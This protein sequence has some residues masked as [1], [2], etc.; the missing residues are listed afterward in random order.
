MMSSKFGVLQVAGVFM[1]AMISLWLAPPVTAGASSDG[2]SIS[3]FTAASISVGARTETEVV[4]VGL[5]I[6]LRNTVGNDANITVTVTE[7]GKTLFAKNFTVPANGSCN[8]SLVWKVKGLGDHTA[9]ATISGDNVTAPATMQATCNVRL[10]PLVEH[11]SPWYTI[12][13]AFSVIILPSIAIWLLIRRM[14][15]GEWLEKTGNGS[16][17]EIVPDKSEEG[18]GKNE[19]PR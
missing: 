13:C 17:G 6:T 9:L 7:N 10:L 19:N 18:A 15:G 4:E 5:N 16:A 2:V 11:P 12:P 14:K 8:L 1:G 3:S